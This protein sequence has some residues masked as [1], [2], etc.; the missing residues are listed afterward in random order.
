MM[1][2][3]FMGQF[4][5]FSPTLLG[6]Q[7]SGITDPRTHM[8]VYTGVATVLTMVIPLMTII[9]ANIGILACVTKSNFKRRKREGTLC[10]KKR[11]TGHL[12]N[13]RNVGQNLPGKKAI[14]TV[15][16]VAWAFVISV[17]PMT[18]RI[19]LQ[20]NQI[21][22]DPCF[23]IVSIEA[24]FLNSISNPLIY[25]ITNQRFRNF[26]Y[27]IGAECLHL[28]RTGSRNSDSLTTSWAQSHKVLD[29]KQRLT[30][31]TL[32]RSVSAKTQ[33]SQVNTPCTPIDQGREKGIHLG[34]TPE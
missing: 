5:F 4:W 25:T 16:C 14:I 27:N 2:I 20:I 32:S 7:P 8:I 12:N 9:L 26:M 17:T 22:I 10:V 21:Y 29:S 11:E 19:L 13:I 6:C 30:R 1:C 28:V 3:H 18:I 23:K 31:M 34:L 33:E 15:S 24:L